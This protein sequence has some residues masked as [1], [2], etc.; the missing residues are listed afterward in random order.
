MNNESDIEIW[1]AGTVKGF[2]FIPY[3]SKLEANVLGFY[4]SSEVE[5]CMRRRR[6][7]PS[8]VTHGYYRG[9]LLPV[10]AN[11]ELFGGWSLAEIHEHFRNLFL[12]D[13][14]EKQMN[15]NT[16]ILRK[17]LSTGEIS[18]KRMNKFIEDVR[19]W[20]AENGVETMDPLKQIK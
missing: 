17:I 15:G 14:V 20:L 3:D 9:V 10:A 4:N 6:T 18:Q 11:C 1:I 19:Q 2:K 8:D 16:I 12:Q 5:Y 13:V 7:K